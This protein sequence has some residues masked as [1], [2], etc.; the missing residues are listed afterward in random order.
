MTL[1]LDGQKERKIEASRLFFL[2]L[3][4][5]FVTMAS[6]FR[7]FVVLFFSFFL[8]LLEEEM[9]VV[10]EK[11]PN[12]PRGREREKKRNQRWVYK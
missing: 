4:F 10:I 5:F 8:F 6:L 1:W 11:N 12:E 7:S 2:S 3:S 9:P